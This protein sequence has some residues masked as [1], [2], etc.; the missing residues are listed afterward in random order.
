MK[1]DDVVKAYTDCGNRIGF[2]WAEL[3]LMKYLPEDKPDGKC[4]EVPKN[5]RKEF[6][7]ELKTYK[8]RKV[9]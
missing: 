8:P 6:V 4:Y 2:F 9:W 5:K 3:I 7:T 1:L